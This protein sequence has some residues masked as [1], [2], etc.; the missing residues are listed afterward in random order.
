VP[1][2]SAVDRLLPDDALSVKPRELGVSI[3]LTVQAGGVRVI[4]LK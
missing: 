3:E 4:E 2:N 1:V